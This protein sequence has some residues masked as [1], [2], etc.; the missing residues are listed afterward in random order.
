M[1]ENDLRDSFTRHEHLAPDTGPL[2]R[3]IDE[4]TGHRRRRRLI[5]RS[6][7]AALA[8]TAVLAVPALLGRQ[9]GAAAPVEVAQPPS[10]P[11]VAADGPLDVLLI[12]VDGDGAAAGADTVLIAHVPADRQ[13]VYLVSLPR[14]TRLPIPG[15]GDRELSESFVLGGAALTEAAVRG[16]AGIEFDGTVTVRYSAVEAMTD[17]VGGVELCL[18]EPVVSAGTGRRYAAGCTGF[19]GADAVDLLRQRDDPNRDRN[20]RAFLHAMASEAADAGVL[21]VVGAAGDGLTLDRGG[22]GLTAAIT[23]LDLRDKPVVGLTG[24]ADALG[25]LRDG[26]LPGWAEAHPDR[27]TD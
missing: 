19:D 13:A 22:L 24:S 3:A 1:I 27:T 12:G 4:V 15:H 16:I 17:A 8:V 14:D 7:G 18:D 6:V 26:A 10:P 21:R 9:T 5:N 11:A 25:A 20:G 2:R 23:G